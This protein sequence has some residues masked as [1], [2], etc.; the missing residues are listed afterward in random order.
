LLKK[1]SI[2]LL[3]LLAFSLVLISCGP[4]ET[5]DEEAESPEALSPKH[6]G[7]LSSAY[8]APGNLDPAFLSTVI[9]EYIARQFSDHLVFI[10]E[11]NL[12]DITR[13]VAEHWEGDEDAKIWTFKLRQGIMFHDGKE[14]TS[15]DVK[16]TYDRLRDPDIGAATV[17]MYENIIDITA[18]DDYT[19]IFELAESNT[20]FLMD[21]ADYHALIMDADNDDFATNW[22]GTGPFM[23]ERYEPEDRIILVRNP[24]YWMTD[25][26]GYPLPYLDSMEIIFLSDSTAQIEA[27]RGGQINYLFYLPT[28]FIPGLEADPDIV[29]YQAPSN[30]TYVLRM[31]SDEG[32]ASDV[33]VRQALKAGTDRSA[34]LEGAVGGLGT[35]GRD[36]PIGPA[37]GDFYLDVPEPER[38][39][40]KAIELLEEAGYGD[41]LDITITTQESSPIPAIA[42]I[43]KEQMADIGVNVDIQLV[44]SDIY[45]GADDMWLEAP[46][47]ITDWG[48]RPYPQ[49]Y[50]DLAYTCGA[51]WN[52][53]HFCDPE[54]DEL[55]AAV[56]KEMDHD[57]RVR[58][59]HE[60][61]ELFIERG[62]IIIPFF[63]NN[64]WAAHENVKGLV[65]TSGLGTAMDL[66]AVYLED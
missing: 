16:F 44:P 20:D 57:E 38:D 55:A 42:T 11:D 63:I 31:R 25:A 50:L 37:Y 66:R 9:D 60:I 32:P 23:V 1:L 40:E 27:L 28:E 17:G 12:P 22:N 59:Y 34:I 8:Y 48:A 10:D 3:L 49:P 5:V 4:T 21:L 56:A 51:P 35:T 2:L 65:P 43:W 15:L 47:G 36:T 54:L 26:D 53:S 29:V 52:E 58:L 7:T 30:T 61:Q 62:P 64:L 24:N 19:V 46:F 41:G 45:Y 6:G 33:R 39:V 13:S 14:M 18:P